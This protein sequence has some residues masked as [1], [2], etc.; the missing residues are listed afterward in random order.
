MEF[1]QTQNIIFNAA[2][3]YNVEY[4]N[5][6]RIDHFSS[7]EDLSRLLIKYLNREWEIEYNGESSFE[8]LNWIKLKKNGY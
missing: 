4:K 2:W 7:F 5:F 6:S 8:F 1:A 3:N